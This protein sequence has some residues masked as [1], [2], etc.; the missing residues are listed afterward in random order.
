MEACVQLAQ[1]LT[2]R[3][4]ELVEVPM[5]ELSCN[6]SQYRRDI[7]GDRCPVCNEYMPDSNS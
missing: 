1:E 3:P 5:Q 6:H 4:F 2:T 7:H